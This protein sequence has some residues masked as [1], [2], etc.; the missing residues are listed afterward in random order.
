M[1]NFFSFTFLRTIFRKSM[2]LYWSN[3]LGKVLSAI[4]P[5][6]REIETTKAVVL[7]DNFFSSISMFLFRKLHSWLGISF[8]VKQDSSMYTIGIFYSFSVW[9]LALQY[10]TALSLNGK[11][12]SGTTFTFRITFFRIPCFLYMLERVWREMRH[13][14]IS[15]CKYM[16]LS[17]RLFPTILFKFC[18]LVARVIKF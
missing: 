5:I 12:F 10:S 7:V 2:N 9:I 14:G 3:D 16:H 18:S 11:D 13:V 4:I 15:R 17:V 1:A 8:V 6:L